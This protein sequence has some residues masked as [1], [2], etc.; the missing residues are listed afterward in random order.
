MDVVRLLVAWAPLTIEDIFRASATF[1]RPYSSIK[2]CREEL[3]EMTRAGVVARK[4]IPGVTM[5]SRPFAYHLRR[6]AA[7]LEPRVADIPR[8]NSVFYG[9]S[10]HP[11]HALAI[12]ELGSFLEAHAAQ[13]PRAV[14]LERIRDRQFSANLDDPHMTNLIPD[15]TLA[16]YL[17]GKVKLLFVELVNETSVINPGAANRDKRSFAAKVSKYQRFNTMRRSH[18]TWQRLEHAYGRIGG[19]QVLVVSTRPNTE[20]LLSAARDNNTMFLFASLDDIRKTKNLYASRVWWLPAAARW[21]RA[22][23]Q[24][25]RLL[26][27]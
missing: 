18:E 6:G 14:V 3:L 27:H 19:F 1:V 23:P 21:K 8:S 12:G 10:R 7:A 13:H 4:P 2:R 9:V 15:A 25:T 20:H 26:D 22:R 5:G 11:W 16:V 24:L 17:D